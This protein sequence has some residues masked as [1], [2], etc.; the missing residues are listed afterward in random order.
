M[1]SNPSPAVEVAVPTMGVLEGTASSKTLSRSLWPSGI[2]LASCSLIEAPK[3]FVSF[4][5]LLREALTKKLRCRV[6]EKVILI[7]QVHQR[8]IQTLNSTSAAFPVHL[9][10]GI[11]ER[12]KGSLCCL[13]SCLWG[14]LAF[15]SFL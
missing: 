9:H 14:E 11:A 8:G 13:H 4:L 7:G 3:F 10:R 2:G 15:G 5:S 6:F 12:F 1:L